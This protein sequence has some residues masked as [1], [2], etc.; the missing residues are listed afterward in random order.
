M[1]LTWVCGLRMTSTS[2]LSTWPVGY[3]G[4]AFAVGFRPVRVA[5][6][7]PAATRLRLGDHVRAGAG[8][9][10]AERSSFGVPCGTGA[11]NISAELVGEGASR[12]G[13]VDD[14]FAGLVVGLDP[15]DAALLGF[16][17]LFGADDVGVEGRAAGVDLEDAFDRVGEVGG[18]DRFAVGVFEALAQEERVGL[19]AVGDFRQFFGEARDDFGAFGCRSRAC[20]SAAGCRP[21]P[22]RSSLR[23][24]R[25]AAGP[26]SRGRRRRCVEVPPSRAAFAAA[27]PPPPASIA[28]A[29]CRRPRPDATALPTAASAIRPARPLQDFFNRK[30]Q[31][32]HGLDLRD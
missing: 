32:L 6:V 27:S 28:V 4:I 31:L 15:G 14:D 17:E 8:G 3:S 23:P 24:C 26:C 18:F 11:T 12:L 16:R 10:L 29:R 9:G 2:I 30:S 19:A 5:F 1:S 21:R 7:F 25:R 13:Q 22:S 20:R